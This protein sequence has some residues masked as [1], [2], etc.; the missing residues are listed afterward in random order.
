MAYVAKFEQWIPLP[1]ERVFEFFGNPENLPRIMPPWIKVRVD[2]AKFVQP[3]DARVGGKFAGT[4][5][6]VT[7]SFRPVPF[8]PFRIRS[9]A[10]IVGFAMDHF[11]EDAHSDMLFKSWHHRHEFISER[12]AGF[13]GTIVRDV[14]TYELALGPLSAIVNAFFVARQMRATFEF[15]QHVVERLLLQ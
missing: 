7:V 5:S 15:R 3:P 1:L 13:A 12:R 4:G 2:D 9:Q 10:N 11:F 6:V 8:L 14:V